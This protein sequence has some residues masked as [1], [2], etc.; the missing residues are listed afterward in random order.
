MPAA[1]GQFE[2]TEDSRPISVPQ[3]AADVLAGNKAADLME[4]SIHSTVGFQL[5][6]L[7]NESFRGSV[8]RRSNF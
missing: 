4:T 6:F 2:A 1:V 7:L 8:S 3:A 5:L